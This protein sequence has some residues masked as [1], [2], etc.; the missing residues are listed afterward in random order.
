MPASVKQRLAQRW[1][2]RGP[3]ASYARRAQQFPAE[4]RRRRPS[5]GSA[6]GADPAAARPSRR[7]ARCR[8]AAS[9]RRAP[10]LHLGDGLGCRAELRLERRREQHEI[11]TVRFGESAMSVAGTLAPRKRQRQPASANRS[12]AARSPRSCALPA[13]PAASTFGPVGWA[14]LIACRELRHHAARRLAD[15][16]LLGHVQIASMPETP[17]LFLRRHQHAA[18]EVLRRRRRRR[19]R[20]ERGRAPAVSP[21]RHA[22]RYS[23]AKR[24][25]ASLPRA[26]SAPARAACEA[27]E[28]R[29]EHGGDAAMQGGRRFLAQRGGEAPQRRLDGRCRR[30]CGPGRAAQPLDAP[31]EQHADPRPA[32]PPRARARAGGN[33]RANPSSR[34]ARRRAASRCRCAS[35]A[36]AKPAR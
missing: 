2:G 17:D 33:R 10:A 5:A 26:R 20:R 15:E 19:R 7:R 22:V 36:E 30:R 21:S 9:S 8:R 14:R 24:P 23:S 6:V 12:V 16:P 29:V 31:H 32:R 13:T 1:R 11:D 35:A 18:I 28:R 34:R 4:S 25:A 3:A 27:S